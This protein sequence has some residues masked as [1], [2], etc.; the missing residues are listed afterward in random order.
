MK[1]SIRL[2]AL[3]LASAGLVLSSLAAAERSLGPDLI[4]VTSVADSDHTLLFCDGDPQSKVRRAIGEPDEVI[5]GA[6]WVYRRFGRYSRSEVRYVF[7]NHACDTMLVSFLPA[8][9]WAGRRVGEIVQVNSADVPAVAA[10]M[11]KDPEYIAKRVAAARVAL[12]APVPTTDLPFLIHVTAVSG[13]DYSVLF[14][15]GDTEESV[16]KAVGQPSE[17][18]PGEVWA[19]RRYERHNLQEIRGV[20]ERRG[21]ETT[22]VTFTPGAPGSGR[23]VTAIVMAN[24]SSLAGIVECLKKDPESLRR[25]VMAWHAPA[26]DVRASISRTR[27]P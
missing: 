7:P 11:L 26:G 5:G 12:P 25:R 19:Y 15:D 9:G 13:H 27:T 3:F 2:P 23:T 21:C 18:L 16:L 17:I 22:L 14:R 1:S 6:V 4:H 24:P 20:A 8:S 10:T